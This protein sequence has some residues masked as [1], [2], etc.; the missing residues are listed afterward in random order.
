[1][2]EIFSYDVDGDS[3]YAVFHEPV[4]RSSDTGIVMLSALGY[5]VG[6]QRFFVQAA[7]SLAQM[8]CPVLRTDLR[9]YGDSTGSNLAGQRYSEERERRFG[10]EIQQACEM[11]RERFHLEKVVLVTECGAGRYALWASRHCPEVIGFILLSTPLWTEEER[12]AY[13]AGH[14]QRVVVKKLLSG[15]RWLR[16]LRNPEELRGDIK[17]FARFLVDLV[18]GKKDERSRIA[19]S[20]LAELLKILGSGR[21]V[22]A[23]YGS[24]D[25]LGDG[26]VEEVRKNPKLRPFSET[27]ALAYEIFSGADHDFLDREFRNRILQ[28]CQQWLAETMQVVEPA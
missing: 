1:M 12:L 5:R 11:I 8:G 7:R 10:R 23:I 17:R 3:V 19:P 25:V 6:N 26:F 9:G 16:V 14:E 13:M 27:G 22:L 15:K 20:L 2:D 21:R 18:P 28:R 24:L 4:G